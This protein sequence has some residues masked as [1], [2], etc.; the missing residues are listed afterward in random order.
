MKQTFI[1]NGNF[2]EKLN[3]KFQLY[4]ER[5]DTQ[6]LKGK[7]NKRLGNIGKTL[8]YAAIMIKLRGLYQT[9]QGTYC[10]SYQK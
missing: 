4:I 8:T 2:G 3:A 1:K 5:T 6:N 10:N 7:T 9:H